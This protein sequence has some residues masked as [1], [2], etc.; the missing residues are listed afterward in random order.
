[1][2][3]VFASELI[4]CQNLKN[5]SVQKESKAIEKNEF[6]DLISWL[7]KGCSD[8]EVLESGWK[9]GSSNETCAQYCQAMETSQ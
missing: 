1:M 9:R 2:L 7:L 3:P 6:Q 4:D 5:V 8:L